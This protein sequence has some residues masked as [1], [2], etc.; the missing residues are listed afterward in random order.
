MIVYM[1]D[2]NTVSHLIRGDIPQICARLVEVPMNSIALSAVTKGELLFGLAKRGYPEGLS[3]RV[4]KFLERVNIL[5][6]SEGTAHVYAQLRAACETAGRPL[7]P[8]DMMIAAHAQHTNSIL[9]TRDKAF[10]RIPGG[11]KTEDWTL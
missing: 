1:L 10:S 5:P 2:T 3:L 6:W 4:T 9:V 7:A 8:L 11:L